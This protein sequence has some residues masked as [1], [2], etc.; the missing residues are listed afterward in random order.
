MR[1]FDAFSDRHQDSAQGGLLHELAWVDR[2]RSFRRDPWGARAA[3]AFFG[4]ESCSSGSPLLADRWADRSAKPDLCARL[5]D[6]RAL[7]SVKLIREG[8]STDSDS[9]PMHHAARWRF[10]SAHLEGA[11]PDPADPSGAPARAALLSHFIDGEPLGAQPA[12]ARAAALDFLI[13]SWDRICHSAVA[14]SGSDPADWLLIARESASD[15]AEL[16]DARAL[17][18]DQAVAF[19]RSE[20]PS[21]KPPKDGQI[22]TLGSRLL[23]LQRGQ[24]LSL[25]AQRDI[26]IKINAK[27]LFDRAEPLPELALR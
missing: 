7:I 18:V 11:L 21:I 8:S 25:G 23:H 6:Q 12:E 5:G 3:L 14:G 20:P 9:G 4:S 16:L 19:L 10:E 22:G 24:A 27:A 17:R 15:P 13:A 1:A 2:L 26:Q